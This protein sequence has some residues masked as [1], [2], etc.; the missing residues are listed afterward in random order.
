[1]EG[2]KINN[3]QEIFFLTTSGIFSMKAI[4]MFPR[5]K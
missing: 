1:M 5:E 2:E 3:S 4:S